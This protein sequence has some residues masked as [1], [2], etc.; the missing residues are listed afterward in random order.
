MKKL[1]QLFI[2]F[3]EATR[4]RR[5]QAVPEKLIFVSIRTNSKKS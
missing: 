1:K 5:N 3:A 4:I 2:C